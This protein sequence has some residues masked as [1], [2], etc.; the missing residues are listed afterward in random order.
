MVAAS[1]S[2]AVAWQETA[3]EAQ[4]RPSLPRSGHCTVNLP[5]GDDGLDV[6]IFGGYTET[7]S[8]QREACNETWAFSS[9]TGVWQQLQTTGG[10]PRVRL[11]AQAVRVGSEVFVIGGWDPGHKQDGGEF[12]SDIWALDL[13]SREWRQV[14]LNQQGEQLPP[15][16]RFQ[17]VAMGDDIY[18]HTH[19]NTQDILKLSTAAAPDGL[20][21]T[22]VPVAAPEGAPFSR[23]LHSLTAVGDSLY[24]F[25]GAPKS[26]GMLNDLWRLDTAAERLEWQQ[27]SPSGTAPH[28]RCSHTAVAVGSDIVF[29]G[30]SYYKEDGSGLQPLDD[31]FV[32][33][34]EKL[35]WQWPEVNDAKPAAR[36]AAT[37]ALLPDGRIL[38][39]GGWYPFKETYNDTWILST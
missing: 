7:D 28:P 38:L 15:I 4:K 16:S 1:A 14:Q 32:L 21:L 13:A 24:L 6:L 12:L 34:T 2:A 29:H 37:A 31:T 5:D 27:L 3:L 8:K 9:A 10:P 19:R 36:N 23:G 33:N 22:S 39:H 11:A 20:E 30:G 18:I 35:E 17:A 25:G 26:G